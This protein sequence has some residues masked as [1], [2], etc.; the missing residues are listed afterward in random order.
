MNTIEMLGEL[1]KDKKKKFVAKDNNDRECFARVQDG[2]RNY[3]DGMV[4]IDFYP[5]ETEEFVLN[6]TTMSYDWEEVKPKRV[7]TEKDIMLLKLLDGKV[8]YIAV[9][10]DGSLRGHATKPFLDDEYIW[11]NMS[12]DGSKDLEIFNDICSFT[13]EESPINIKKALEEIN[14][15]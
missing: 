8:E 3:T 11:W 1:M 14:G 4:V 15:N 7:Y 12:D 2:F 13:F 5:N 10:K 6:D 9:D